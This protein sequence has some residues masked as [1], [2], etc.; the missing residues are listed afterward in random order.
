MKGD[1]TNNPDDWRNGQQFQLAKAKIVRLLSSGKKF[2]ENELKQL[3]PN[4]KD[5]IPAIVTDLAY[6]Q[7]A[8][9]NNNEKNRSIVMKS[10]KKSN[11]IEKIYTF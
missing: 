7:E 5:I 9:V 2:T 1:Y 3:L 6:K 11:E 4:L 10:K 8:F